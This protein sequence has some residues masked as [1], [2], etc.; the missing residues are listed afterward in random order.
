MKK[1]KKKLFSHVP[2]E[3]REEVYEESMTDRCGLEGL[4]TSAYKEIRHALVSGYEREFNRIDSYVRKR[5]ISSK[6]GE[7]VW[8][9]VQME[10]LMVLV[11][12]MIDRPC[13][14]VSSDDIALDF[15]DR[16]RGSRHD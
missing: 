15:S 9:L 8:L 3:V 14:G 10:S 7:L 6:E 4:D 12:K 16:V 2:E 11:K 13:G 1:K 5:L